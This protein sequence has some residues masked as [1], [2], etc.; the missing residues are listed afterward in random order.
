MNQR[1]VAN[2]KALRSNQTDAESLLWRHF[3]AHRLAG[4]KFRRQQTIGPYIVDFVCF[5]KRLIIE[6]DGGQHLESDRDMRRDAWLVEQGFSILRFW[7]NEV[8]QNTEGV[9]ERILQAITAPLP[10][11][12]PAVGRG[13]L[14]D[15][16]VPEAHRPAPAL[17]RGALKSDEVSETPRP[18]AGEGQGRGG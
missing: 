6:V 7:N 12:S 9:L 15:E 13:A 10:N 18:T 4:A 11:P 17:G 5:D 8:F 16:A 2:A 14:K 3:R 1:N